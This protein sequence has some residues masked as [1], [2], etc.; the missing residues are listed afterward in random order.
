MASAMEN[1]RIL[2]LFLVGVKDGR[3]AQRSTAADFAKSSHE[4][5]DF[6]KDVSGW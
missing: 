3:F 2:N 6:L 1:Q 4:G 5:R